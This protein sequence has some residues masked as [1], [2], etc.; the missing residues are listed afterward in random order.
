MKIDPL[1]RGQMP[2]IGAAEPFTAVGSHVYGWQVRI[3]GNRPLATPAVASGKV[4]IGGGFGSYEF[5][6]FHADTGSLAWRY[7]TEDDGP[8]AAVVAEERVVFNTESC[9]LE[10]LTEA[11][12]RV[13]KLWLGDPLLSMPAVGTG[14]V[15]IAYPDSRGDRRHYLAAFALH[16]GRELWRSPIPGELITCPVL[17]DGHVYATTLDGTLSCF[18]QA[19]G[20][21]LWTEQK[22]ATSSP[23]VW[24]GQCYFSQRTEEQKK[25]A[26]GVETQRRERMSRK[27][28][29]AGTVTQSFDAT[30]CDA[31]YLDHAK[32]S[33]RSAVYR[34]HEMYDTSVG[35]GS[36]KGDMKEHQSVHNLGTGHVS[37]VWAYQG[38]KPV[39]SRGKMYTG[40]GD[41]VHCVEPDTQAVLWKKPVR[42]DGAGEVLDAVTTPPA[43]VNGKLFLGTNDGRLLCL[44]ATT[45]E[46]L[47]S[48]Q[49][50][51]PVLFQPAVVGGRVFVGTACGMLFGLET[52]DRND[53]G[54]RMWGATP[55]HNGEVE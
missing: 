34:A 20:A 53:D 25:T 55:A 22:D 30:I 5:Y 43:V 16:D 52:G 47:W 42:R 2:E 51:S 40:Q 8:T 48:V 28:S 18:E 4:Y 19:S 10:V 33:A 3:P 36:H 1:L 54:W 27:P 31:D 15:F 24:K 14:R 45:G 29:G 37:A 9:E 35:F 46:E 7:Q 39:L 12:E 11:G 13:W 32:R 38:S 26:A 41:S 6:A 49:L 21:L 44:S 17:A 23:A 50:G